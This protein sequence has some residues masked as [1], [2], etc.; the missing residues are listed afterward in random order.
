MRKSSTPE[1]FLNATDRGELDIEE[2]KRW[3]EKEYLSKYANLRV[4]NEKGKYKRKT[5]WDKSKKSKTKKKEECLVVPV[6]Y[7]DRNEPMFLAYG[8]G[9]EFKSKLPKLFGNP[10]TECLIVYKNNKK[11]HD[12]FLIQIAYDRFNINKKDGWLD[13]EKLDG[14]ILTTDWEDNIHNGAFYENGI[15]TKRFLP[16]NARVSGCNVYTT[17]HQSWHVESDGAL[18]ITLTVTNH[19]HCID[20]GGSMPGGGN[21]FP[22]EYPQDYFVNG[23][24]GYYNPS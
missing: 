21:Y 7:E 8:E 1:E 18:V 2:A 12:A 4:S 19:W 20:S 3:F 23:G 5:N 24:Q 6:S 9:E 15:A 22:P 11:Q 14:W 10:I 13:L 17:S 16:K